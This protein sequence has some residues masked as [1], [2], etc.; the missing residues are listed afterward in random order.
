MIWAVLLLLSVVAAVHWFDY[1]RSVQEYTI[2]QPA[3]LEDV[4]SVMGDKTPVVVEIGALPWRP[5]VATV[6]SWTVSVAA[7]GD[8]D[9]GLLNMPIGTW[10]KT[11]AGDRPA[12]VNATELAEEMGLT[13]GLAELDDSRAFWWMPGLMDPAVGILEAGGVKGLTWVSSERRWFGC[14]G[15]APVVLWLV[16]SRYRRYLPEAASDA[17]AAPVDPWTLTVAEAP[18]I[19]RV[20]FV[21]V[22]VRPGWCLGIPAH[23]GYAVRGEGEGDSWW[24]S[25]DQHSPL[26]RLLG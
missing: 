24:W 5:E 25:A 7:G 16:H 20:Q 1:Q 13:T 21:E 17:A 23:W 4:R 12:I 15:G 11:P 19:G 10:L 18:W 22:R 2:A 14:S 6:A 26:S 3:T 8:D 9:S